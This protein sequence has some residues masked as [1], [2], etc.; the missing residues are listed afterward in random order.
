MDSWEASGFFYYCDKMVSDARKLAAD[1][2][3][4][5]RI[6]KALLTSSFLICKCGEI[7]IDPSTIVEIYLD[8]DGI[9]TLEFNNG[10]PDLQIRYR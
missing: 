1:G 2:A 3:D 5:K 8:L 9:I 4:D 10:L 7:Q 6:G